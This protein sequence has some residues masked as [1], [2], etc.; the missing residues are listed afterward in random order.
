MN[1]NTSPALAL[2]TRLTGILKLVGLKNNAAALLLS[3]DHNFK[4]WR[5][6]ASRGKN[7]GIVAKTEG[8]E[9]RKEIILEKRF[10]F[11]MS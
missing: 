2:E 10:S 9:N 3:C 5:Q 1:Q 7:H 6:K 4:R 11:L 8:G